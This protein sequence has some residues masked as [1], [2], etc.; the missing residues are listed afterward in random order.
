[1]K[2]ENKT[3]NTVE[4]LF[5]N[6]VTAECKV[7][8][9]KGTIICRKELINGAVQYGIQPRCSE[10]SNY[11]SD[12]KSI[13]E[14][15]IIAK[16]KSEKVEFKFDCGQKVRNFIN[17]FVGTIIERR[18]WANGCIQYI[19]E[20]EMIKTDLQGFVRQ[21]DKCWE[22]ELELIEDEKLPINKKRTGGETT[23]FSS[24]ESL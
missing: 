18:Q 13:D 22:Q 16:K 1:M 23:S 19:V 8:G 5:A 17:G 9:F 7:T 15:Y 21:E 24:V 11:I 4:F 14:G 3:E 20:G 10:D 2:K 6:G 12:A